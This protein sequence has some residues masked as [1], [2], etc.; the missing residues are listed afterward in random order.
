MTVLQYQLP[1][2]ATTPQRRL[3]G[4]GTLHAGPRWTLSVRSIRAAIA[5]ARE[6]APTR[7]APSAERIA[8]AVI[9]NVDSLA[10]SDRAVL[11]VVVGALLR[12]KN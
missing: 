4:L 9:D 1:L 8:D 6:A 11:G 2:P 10:A 7:R 3:K 5:A 12:P